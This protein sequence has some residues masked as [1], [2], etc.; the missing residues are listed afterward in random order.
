MSYKPSDLQPVYDPAR[1]WAHFVL[2]TEPAHG[3]ASAGLNGMVSIE[4]ESPYVREWL[5]RLQ[6]CKPN[7]LHTTL[8]SS[9]KIP[10]LF[11]ACVRDDKDSPSAVGGSG[12]VCHQ[13]FIDQE[14]GLSVVAR[15]Y[16][17]VGGNI[18]TWTHLT[19]APL[20]LRP[21]DDFHRLIIDQ[22]G[23]FWTRTKNGLLSLLP[24]TRAGGYGTG[25][26]GG[27]PTE[28]ARYITR[29]IASDGKD[30]AARGGRYDTDPD[31]Q[32]ARWV[33]SEAA[34]RTQELTL[35]DLKALQH[36]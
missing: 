5:S 10:E 24:E 34:T 36:G 2:Y 9:E 23:P 16:R 22:T 11:H 12:C 6:P 28:L 20:D 7:T 25:Y 15:H 14:F 31:P 27:G 30:T 8:V 21:G 33:S 13:T 19:F 35:K 32:I 17:T 29:L 1:G 18:E 3:F 4:Q 26:G